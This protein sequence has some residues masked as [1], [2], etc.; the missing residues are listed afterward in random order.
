MVTLVFGL[1]L[2]GVSL[3]LAACVV[4]AC[5]YLAG[6]GLSSW[7]AGIVSFWRRFVRL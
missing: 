1:A 4:F 7:L 6:G 3:A 5:A 2:L